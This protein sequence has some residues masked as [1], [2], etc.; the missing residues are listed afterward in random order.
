[1]QLL[2]KYNIRYVAG[3]VF[4]LDCAR[5]DAPRSSFRFLGR[6][7]DHISHTPWQLGWNYVI[8]FWPKE[9]NK[10]MVTIK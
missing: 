6:E 2:E 7:K 8:W 10:N 4:L 5:L 9:Y 3:T 1:M